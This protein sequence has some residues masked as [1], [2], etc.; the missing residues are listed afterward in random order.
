MPINPNI[1]LGVQQQQPVNM[2][3]Q[4]GQIYALKGAKQEFEGNEA[5]REAYAQGGDLNDPAFRQRVMAANP[6]LGSQLI[7]TS[8]ETSKLQNEAV[9]KRIELSREMLTG[10]NTP[11]DYLAWHESNHKD[12]VLGSYLSQ[13]GV[14]AEDSRAK[15]MAEL[16]KPGGLERL[17]RES[18]LGAGKLQQELMQT[19]R[20]VQVANIGAAAPLGQLAL[21]TKKFDL[22]QTQQAELS[23]ILR[24]EAPIG[25]PSVT[26]APIGGGGGPAVTGGPSAATP[27]GAGSVPTGASAVA[28]VAA[29]ATAPNVNALNATPGAPAAAGNVNALTEGAVPPQIAQMQSQ[30]GQ[31]IRVGTPKAL[32]AADALIKQHNMLMPSQQI[33]QN[34]KGEYIRVDQRGGSSTP[35]LDASGQPLV[36]KLPPEQ[37]ESTYRQVVGKSAGERDVGIATSATAAAG[38]LPKLYETLD[39][40]KTSDAITGFGAGVI[41]N[42]EAFRAKFANDIKAGKRVADTEILDAMLGSDVF[43]MIQ[44][45]GVGAKGMDTPAEREFL[46]SVMTGTINMD[47]AALIKLTDIRKNIEER[48]IK[49]Y[50]EAVD[51]GQLNRFFETQ[52]VKPEKIEAPKY[53]PRLKQVDQDALNWAKT[54]PND[55]RAA[56]ILQRLGM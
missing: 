47:K 50:N 27:V 13:R 53:E 29:P 39:Q 19:E 25:A 49:R 9:A 33:V 2:L 38:N 1:A 45:L 52:G 31:L 43:P 7:K 28:P 37:F 41:K 12:P 46:R 22:E 18:A 11:E 56:Q 40:L 6:K 26:N 23:R 44:S 16:G 42:I 4:L 5:L 21:A 48:A 34:Q 24:G 3:G 55:P 35:V 17:K 8:A 20:S 54:N 10:I 14:T 15:I 51:S 32:A 30:I 36:G